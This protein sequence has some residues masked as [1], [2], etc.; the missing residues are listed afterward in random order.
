MAEAPEEKFPEEKKIDFKDI[1]TSS[2][3]VLDL[4]KMAKEVA[5][6]DI[7]VLIT[8][9]TGTGKELIA[10]AIHNNSQKKDGPFV[11]VNCAGLPDTLLESELFGHEKGAFKGASS[12]K[13]GKFELANGGTLF[14]DEVGDLS[15]ASQP[16]TLRAIEEKSIERLGGKKPIIIDCRI[17]AATNKDLNEEIRMDA[18]RKDLF[19]R[20]CEVQFQIPPLRDRKDDIPLFVD[21]FVVEFNQKFNKSVKGASDVV[22][23]YLTRYD[24]PGNVRELK[25]VIKLGMALINRE[26]MWLEDL[27][28]NIQ[29]VSSDHA[30]L[31]SQ[32][33][34]MDEME[35]KHI[36][37]VLEMCRK[38]KVKVAKLLDISRPTL[39]RK[40]KKFKIEL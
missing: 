29:L 35:K 36:Q 38:N 9:E 10:R 7:N 19:Y 23:S 34:S 24:W 17:I 15:P 21:Q 25:S 26:Q 31:W 12:M 16:K 40:I 27:P 28:F 14:L 3:E 37:K 5:K 6:S 33:L 22:R 13:K 8:G 4:L 18:F 32:D 11:V 2:K 30:D 39:D 1:I 20:I